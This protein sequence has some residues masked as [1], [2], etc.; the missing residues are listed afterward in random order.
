MDSFVEMRHFVAGNAAMTGR[1]QQDPELHFDKWLFRRAC[2]FVVQTAL[3]RTS[4]QCVF[5]RYCRYHHGTIT[6][7]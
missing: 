3:W 1:M 7:R 2:G 5:I 4:R 6:C